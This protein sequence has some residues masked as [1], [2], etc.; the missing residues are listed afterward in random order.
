[1]QTVT[2]GSVRQGEIEERVKKL[3]ELFANDPAVARLEYRFGADW[4]GDDSLFIKVI[5]NKQT[6]TATVLRLSKEIFNALLRVVRSEEL[7]LH[8]YFN[9]VSTPENGQ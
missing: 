9:F 3:Q 6:P 7:D 5:L 4:S 1:M 2:L 8:A